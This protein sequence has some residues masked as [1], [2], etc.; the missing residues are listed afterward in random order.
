MDVSQ[1]KTQVNETVVNSMIAYLDEYDGDGYTKE[2]I[3]KCEALL[4]EYLDA[5]AAITDPTDE[6]IMAQVKTVV[7]ALNDL[8]EA[9]DYS[10]IETEEREAIWEIIQSAAEACGL[11][12]V[13][14]DVT[15]EWREW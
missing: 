11:Q 15:E 12:D 7:L 14:D 1:L 8:N 5:L 6:L 3:A 13:P 9:V 4:C 2:D 10:M